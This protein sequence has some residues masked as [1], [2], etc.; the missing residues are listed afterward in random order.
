MAGLF[1]TAP[2]HLS[3]VN[4]D[5][6]LLYVA[7]HNVIANAAKFTR[8]GDTIE[9]RGLEEEGAV[10]IEVADTGAGIPDGETAMVFE[11]LAR[12]SNARGI[13]GSGLGL[14]LVHA[15]VERHG[16]RCTI[17]SRLGKGTSVRLTLPLR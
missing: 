16:G 13:P 2:W 5:P 15:I 10:S 3:P 17:R 4:G 12:A 9:V 11:E 8:P 7:V 1:P 14:P 6:D